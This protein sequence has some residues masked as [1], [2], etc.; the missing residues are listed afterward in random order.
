MAAAG[1]AAGAGG[2]AGS[3]AEVPGRQ[4]ELRDGFEWCGSRAEEAACGLCSAPAHSPLETCCCASR[5]CAECFGSDTEQRQEELSRKWEREMWRFRWGESKYPGFVLPPCPFCGDKAAVGGLR[6]R[7]KTQDE[8]Y[9]GRL[10]VRCLTCAEVLTFAEHAAHQCDLQRAERPA[11]ASRALAAA[12]AEA[13]L[14]PWAREA[15]ASAAG[16]APAACPP[17]PSSSLTRAELALHELGELLISCKMQQHSVKVM[18]AGIRTVGQLA[19]AE[20]ERITQAGVPHG[21]AL[22]L[23]GKAQ[24]AARSAARAAS[25]G[26]QST[27]ETPVSPAEAA[28]LARHG[29]ARPIPG[30][31]LFLC[32][33]A[34]EAEFIRR[35]I[36]GV[37][38]NGLR[39]QQMRQV[40]KGWLCVL[41]TPEQRLRGVWVAEDSPKRDICPGLGDGAPGEGR[42]PLQVRVSRMLEATVKYAQWISITPP[43]LGF[44]FGREPATQLLQAFDQASRLTGPSQ[45]P[46]AAHGAPGGLPPSPT[47][48]ARN[49]LPAA[50]GALSAGGQQPGS[51]VRLVHSAPGQGKGAPPQTPAGRGVPPALAEL[52]LPAVPP[53]ARGAPQWGQKGPFGAPGGGGGKGP[54]AVKGPPAGKGGWY[55]GGWGGGEGGAWGGGGG[56]GGGGVWGGGAWGGGGGRGGGGVWGGGAWGGGGWGGRGGY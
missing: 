51:G 9:P 47:A 2:A 35:G 54:P 33:Y 39:R 42:F 50:Q 8:G 37:P 23:R 48:A 38:W 49:G 18:Y 21:H 45:P 32:D 15:D 30:V 5:V 29:F 1:P 25:E 26:A 28:L 14:R 24:Q 3:D 20:T 27:P 12:E 53:A 31:A 4:Y 36:F 7:D 52:V 13:R 40:E 16:A 41:L 22:L 55:G 46:A 6:V 11:E 17:I 34:A 10:P 56:R 19:R 43:A 44:V